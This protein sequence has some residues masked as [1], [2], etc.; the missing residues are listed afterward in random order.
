LDATVFPN[1]GGFIHV[2]PASR[3]GGLCDS[4][5]AFINKY[6]RSVRHEETL[7][8]PPT[9]ITIGEPK[10][11]GHGNTDTAVFRPRRKRRATAS[12]YFSSDKNDTLP[13][14]PPP[15]P[16]PP[17]MPESASSEI[18]DPPISLENL[19]HS[20]PEPFIPRNAK[21]V[22][23]HLPL[24]D[25]DPAP[26]D[27]PLKDPDTASADIPLKDSDTAPAD[28]AI[29]STATADGVPVMTVTKGRRLRG[30]VRS[31]PS[32]STG[33]TRR[34]S[35]T[36]LDQD[37]FVCDSG[38]GRR[39]TITERAW[40]IIGGETGITAKLNPYQ[41]NDIFEHPVV[42]AVTKAHISGRPDPVLLK[43]HYA[44]YI[45]MEHDP[46]ET[47][48][49]MTTMDI[50]NH[51]IQINGIHPNDEKCGITVDGTFL[52]FDW[53][54]ETIFFR[55][56]KPT[57]AELDRYEV[58]E[59]NSPAPPAST[60]IRRKR[61][62]PDP[63]WESSFSKLPMSELRKRFA[64]L[65]EEPIKKTLD[66]TTQ[67]Y[68]DIKEETQS[69]PQ[70]HFR[71]R[72]KAIPFN[73]QNEVVSTDF[74]YLS[75]KTSQGHIGAQFFCGVN[76]K[77]WHIFP[78]HKESQNVT[79]LQD[80]FRSEGPPIA[81]K[82]DNAQSQ[83]GTKWTQILRD[84]K[85]AST[86]TEPHHPHQNPAEPEWGRLSN[87]VKNCLRQ[88]NAP[89]SLSHWCMLWCCQVNNH[90]SRRSLNHKTPE[91]VST[92]RTPDISKFRFHFY[93]PLWYFVP[94]LKTPKDTLLKARFL[95]LADSCGD[96]MTYYI[97]TE[98]EN[99][100]IRRQV[101]M[102]S[103]I[104]SRR[105][106][107]GQATEYVNENPDMESFTLSL[108]EHQAAFNPTS[109]SLEVPL[110][111]AGE[112]IS[113]LPSEA[114]Q[115]AKLSTLDDIQPDSESEQP[116][117]EEIASLPMNDPS[118]QLPDEMNA[119]NDAESF[120]AIIE[121]CNP[122]IDGDMTFR[123][124][125]NHTWNDGTLIL[126]AQYVDS[127]QGNVVID[128]PF[129]R[130]KV[131]E[132][133]A[134]AKYIKEWIAEKRHGDRS[135]RPLNDWADRTIKQHAITTRR[136]NK[137]DP[138]WRSKHEDSNTDLVRQILQFKLKRRIRALKTKK[139]GPSRNQRW[140]A[141]KNKE[142]F[143]IKIPNTIEEA[144]EF[145]RQAGN[146]KWADAIAK[147]MGSLDHLNVF[148]FHP[149]TKEFPSSEG[150]QKAPLKMVFDVK[151]EDRRYKARLVVGGHRVDSSHY[152]TYSS[153][154][155]SLSVLI[156]FII[157]QQLDLNIMT[158]DISTAFVT[159]P[160]AEK[161]WATAGDEFG[162]KKGCK[163]EMQRALYGLA[164]SA[165]AFADFLADT[166]TRHGFY[167]S[168]VDPDVWIKP[169][170]YGYD[171]T[172]VHVDDLIVISREPEEHLSLI[173]QEFALRNITSDPTYYLGSSLK[174]L[175]DGRI[176]MN[177]ED[178]VKETIRKYESKF[179]LILKKENTPMPVDAHPE[180]DTSDLLV[181]EQHKEFQHILG[182]AQWIVIRGRIDIT[183]AVSSLSRF[184]T[185]PREGHLLMA[186]RILGYLKKY[187]KKGIIMDP[188]PPII[189][190][191][192]PQTNYE[193][194]THQYK[195]YVEP[196]D[197]HFP[198]PTLAELP[199]TIF[200]DSDH[201][202]DLV[203]GR[204]ITGILAFVG[205]APVYWKSTRQTAVHTS[206][207]GA[208]FTA[209][210]TAVE[211]AITIR[212][213]LRSFGLRITQPTKIFVDNK[214][215]VINSANPA[216]SLNKKT[217]ALAYHFVR[218]NQ[219]AGVVDIQYVRSEDN[220]AD[221]LTKPLN[222]TMLRNLLN[223]F[224]FN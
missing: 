88:F 186:R 4:H 161:V 176:L 31:H 132:P 167:P 55:I 5:R 58:F 174:K 107:I 163:V 148:K 16:R 75:E 34:Q 123:N 169:T 53:D 199:I 8:S 190:N 202:H 118:E 12:D 37:K 22:R 173:E 149:S 2:R 166:L 102:R 97:L 40:T 89:L 95:A 62:L 69:N 224:M 170:E 48:S 110:L 3:W 137:I 108:S 150:W 178:Y 155:D 209:L 84:N 59:L 43:V 140:Q 103:V 168:R 36:S 74:I 54:D 109:P 13:P 126:K 105:K 72:F 164:G 172:A 18:V 21:T 144:L 114:T 210:K 81:I 47:E 146:T 177:M 156:L 119:T 179:K 165:R 115:E 216:S 130:L 206:T 219:A 100:R 9:G 138:D 19:L 189:E 204:S 104:R 185:S 193:D 223:E 94:D 159:A 181:T 222:S 26:A 187:P 30:H 122:N 46:N 25:P 194:F 205:S 153:Q 93:E 158:A 41:T 218:Q 45:S 92:G 217:I 135:D 151:S 79:A 35:I 49:L 112:K 14:P 80:Y 184:G 116:L 182:T 201:A 68:F 66:N 196:I 63:E 160:N 33:T 86:T 207:F 64:Y 32:P 198:K 157:A 15:I 57:Q 83:V 96:A 38:G 82:C 129:K 50:G 1:L 213:H 220:Y 73:R 212:Y 152:N 125:V 27:I 42:S 147:E 61:R 87:M 67:F 85:V 191:K 195:D 44:T 39:P 154:V 192:E 200:S 6:N 183:F 29:P 98:P 23:F 11:D 52:P 120:N 188:K 145:D 71:K 106:N 70:R 99:K 117:Y 51:S 78:L 180:N 136:M 91:E 139:K 101:L 133:V 7:P 203:T 171:F 121:T 56:S 175:P 141:M 197:P 20:D 127:I 24:K 215:V 65:P 60:K 221:L 90:T 143:G 113:A 28:K 214:S 208:E 134:C 17:T 142:K 76:S 124:I 111:V 128:A 10:D 131:D 162:E 77:R 211:V